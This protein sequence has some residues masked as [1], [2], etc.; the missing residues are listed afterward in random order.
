MSYPFVIFMAAVTCSSQSITQ[1]Q[2]AHNAM[3]CCVTMIQCHQSGLIKRETAYCTVNSRRDS[4][5]SI[6]SQAEVCL[7]CFQWH[8]HDMT[9][10][11]I[12][13]VAFR[14][15]LPMRASKKPGC[16]L[17]SQDLLGLTV[18]YRVIL[19]THTYQKLHKPN[20]QTNQQ[21]AGVSEGWQLGC[22]Q[23]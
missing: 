1:V 10:C 8:A 15:S 18:F 14:P 23:R 9:M 5:D 7:H 13:M 20:K 6:L 11:L 17:V 2:G 12:K 19:L 22:S 3:W 4:W 16:T 21:K